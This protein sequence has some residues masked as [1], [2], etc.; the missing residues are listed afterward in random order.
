M[1]RRA[2]VF[3]QLSLDVLSEKKPEKK[4]H[5]K[6]S[7]SVMNTAFGKPKTGGEEKFGQAMFDYVAESHT[8]INDEKKRV[9]DVVREQEMALALDRYLQVQDNKFDARMTRVMQRATEALE[10]LPEEFLAEA[11]VMETACHP[12]RYTRPTHTPPIDGY[13]PGF[14]LDVPQLKSPTP[15]YPP[16]PFRAPTVPSAADPDVLTHECFVGADDV[17][18]YA[19][20][21]EEKWAT[22]ALGNVRKEYPW[23]GPE[24]EQFELYVALNRRALRRQQLLVELSNNDELRALF[25]TGTQEQVDAELE[26][27]GIVPFD[28]EA[29]KPKTVLE[30]QQQGLPEQLNLHHAQ[31]PKYQP[32]RKD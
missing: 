28:L 18:G 15:E 25:E 1:L 16:K 11:T 19:A 29:D 30:H 9:K 10:S 22:T 3:R 2:R 21:L 6:V 20:Q 27:R 8:V 17:A 32:M 7:A 23:T 12:L 4:G 13:E 31:E 14:G 26:R 24:G 5:K